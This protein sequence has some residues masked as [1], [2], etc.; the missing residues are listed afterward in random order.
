[1]LQQQVNEAME[2]WKMELYHLLWEELK[3]GFGHTVAE[4]VAMAACKELELA[5]RRA[6]DCPLRGLIK[7]S[8][9]CPC[10]RK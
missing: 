3:E 2:N 4:K 1:M 9:D 5:V 7:P 10:G 8:R 6:D